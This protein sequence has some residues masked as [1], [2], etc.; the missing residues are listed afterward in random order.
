MATELLIKSSLREWALTFLESRG[1]S[2]VRGGGGGEGGGGEEEGGRE[3]GREGERK[4]GERKKGERKKGG[5]EGREGER[6][7]RSV[8]R[9]RGIKEGVGG[10]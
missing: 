6:G 5:K 1:E 4:K 2:C 9:I 8:G 7:M 3:G 10:I